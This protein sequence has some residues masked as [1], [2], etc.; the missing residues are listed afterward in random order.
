MKGPQLPMTSYV[1]SL[2][3]WLCSLPGL[4]SVQQ[5]GLRFLSY[6]WDSDITLKE[7]LS[8]F[9]SCCPAF[10]EKKM[11]QKKSLP[12]L[13]DKFRQENYHCSCVLQPKSVML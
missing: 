5:W 2:L 12:G 6:W 10:Q 9:F 1:L 11:C 13:A 8:L 4:V 3:C 7:N